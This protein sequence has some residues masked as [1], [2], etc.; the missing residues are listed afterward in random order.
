MRRTLSLVWSLARIPHVALSLLVFPTLL[1]LVLVFIQL[2]LTGVVVKSLS[3][4]K[5]AISRSIKDGAARPDTRVLRRILYGS[6]EARPPLRICR[7]VA[8]PDSETGESQPG[9][10]C[11]PDRLDVAVNTENPSL[12]DVSKIQEWFSGETDRIHVCRLCEP[13]VTISIGKDGKPRTIAR[14][15]YGLSI[16]FLALTKQDNKRLANRAEYLE[17][18]DDFQNTVGSMF[19]FIPEA[20]SPI[21]VG[22]NNPF[23]PLTINVVLIV[24]IAVWLA[25]RA[26]RKVLEYFSHNGV[27]LPLVAATGKSTFYGAVW[28]LTVLRV[29]AFL[30]GSLPMLYGGMEAISGENVFETLMPHALMLAV[31]ALALVATLGFLTTVASI[32]DLKHRDT[33]FAFL[34]RYLPFGVAVVGAFVWAGSYIFVADWAPTF[35]LILSSTP[36]LGLLPLL[37]S[38]ILQLPVWVLV[39]HGSI[40]LVALLLLLRANST[41]FA[42]HLEEV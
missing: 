31:W 10:E 34:Y 14:S 25:L 23:I 9:P 1:S 5:S 21:E 35:R 7:W 11:N 41:W 20:R 29:S 12:L 32:A 26:H 28:T 15:V 33:I 24:M 6:P 8:D 37:M 22:T 17:A 30:L 13:D 18:V 3:T 16:I 2:V 19:V 38:P 40:A 27:L 36:M 39:V 42:A 4:D